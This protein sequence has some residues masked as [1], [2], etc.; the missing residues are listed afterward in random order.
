[1]AITFLAILEMCHV[2]ELD[3]RKDT[4]GKAC[5]ALTITYVTG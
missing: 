2:G 5:P 3:A 1:M 4:G